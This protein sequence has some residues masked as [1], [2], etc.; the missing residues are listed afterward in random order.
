MASPSGRACE[1]SR[2]RGVAAEDSQEMRRSGCRAGSRMGWLPGCSEFVCRRHGLVVT[3]WL[4]GCGALL[5]AFAGACEKFFHAAGHLFG[6]VDGEG[7]VGDVADAH[8]V[9]KLGA[10][11]GAGGHEAFEGGGFLFF[12]AMDGDEDAGGF[13]AGG[14]DD[15]GDVAGRDARVGELA[16]EH[17]ADLFGEGV[18]DSVAVVGS[19]SVLGHKVLTRRTVEDIKVGAFHLMGSGGFWLKSR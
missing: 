11:V 18:G 12:V 14:E 13:A 6:A 9:A 8:A 15:I 5:V 4:I 19:G 16:F 10:D 17:G 2:K 1:V 7:E 3:D